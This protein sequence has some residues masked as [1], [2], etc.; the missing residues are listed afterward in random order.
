[1]ARHF[2]PKKKGFAEGGYVSSDNVPAYV[3][4]NAKGGKVKKVLPAK[5]KARK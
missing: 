1:M 2:P 5:R 4:P 3:P